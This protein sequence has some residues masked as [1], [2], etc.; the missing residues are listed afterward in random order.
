MPFCHLDLITIPAEIPSDPDERASFCQL[1]NDLLANPK[2]KPGTYRHHGVPLVHHAVRTRNLAALQLLGRGG[3]DLNKPFRD[4]VDGPPAAFT[5]TALEEAMLREDIGLVTALFEAGLD[6]MV[7]N[8]QEIN[9]R[10]YRT[11][12]RMGKEPSVEM[13]DTLLD[14]LAGAAELQALEMT[15]AMVLGFFRWKLPYVDLV[16]HLLARIKWE[17]VRTPIATAAL[18]RLGDTLVSH[19][20]VTIHRF[21]PILLAAGA[22]V[23]PEV[24]VDVVDRIRPNAARA[25]TLDLLLAAGAD[26]HEGVTPY[27]GPPWT[28][29]CLTAIVKGDEVAIDRFIG[30][31][32][33]GKASLQILREQFDDNTGGWMAWFNRPSGWVTQA[34]RQAYLGVR[35]RFIALEVEELAVVADA[36]LAE[37][38]G[39]AAPE[40][41]RV[42]ARL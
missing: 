34:G 5:L 23:D 24:L 41:A 2:A 3:V 30:T 7:L 18:T 15:R 22:E 37:A 29:A 39:A 25:K 11:L 36:A 31:G 14:T 32:E 21:V 28:T 6:P 10:P 1:V 20:H 12:L 27:S 16:E 40:P 38:K 4:V 35:R 9:K 8:E 13:V 26:P 42:R 19:K 33:Q 17:W